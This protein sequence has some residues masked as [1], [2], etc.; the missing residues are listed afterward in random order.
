M[1]AKMKALTL[2]QPWASLAIGGWKPY[3]FRPRR[4]P[5]WVENQR[6]VIHA[7][8]RPIVPC[9][10]VELLRDLSDGVN[11]GGL[12]PDCIPFLQRCLREPD[13]IPRSAGLGTVFLGKS[14]L[15]SEL[16]PEEFVNDSDRLDK[17][18]WA[19]PISGPQAFEPI[20][21]ARGYQSFWPWVGGTR[22]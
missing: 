21:P 22:P 3:E 17:A 8:K 20:V 19:L 15:S 18:N 11:C 13:K 12:S 10:V 6:I 7:G 5:A 4:A 9:E 1:M 16:W 2:W 14:V